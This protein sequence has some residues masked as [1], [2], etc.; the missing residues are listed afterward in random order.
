MAA[1]HGRKDKHAH[2][3]MPLGGAGLPGNQVQLT[4]MQTYRITMQSV[5]RASGYVLY[6]TPFCENCTSSCNA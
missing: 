6:N 5:L 3:P 4:V 1:H 2:V